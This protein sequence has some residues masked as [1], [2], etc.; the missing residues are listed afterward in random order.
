MRRLVAHES[1][2]G[3]LRYIDADCNTG[4][5]V[6]TK[7][8]ICDNSMLGG[9]EFRLCSTKVAVFS[10]R[11]AIEH[12]DEAVQATLVA[13]EVAE[14]EEGDTLRLLAEEYHQKRDTMRVGHG[15]GRVQACRRTQNG[16]GGS[17]RCKLSTEIVFAL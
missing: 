5:H 3:M 17:V 12:V 9:H 6:I 14:Q 16:Y 2:A 8:N 15:R 10:N 4:I 11:P 1:I 7:K 13:A